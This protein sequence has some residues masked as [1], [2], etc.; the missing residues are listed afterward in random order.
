[1]LEKDDMTDAQRAYYKKWYAENREHKRVYDA[2][3]IE[4]RRKYR[5]VNREALRV[6]SQKR[7]NVDPEGHR[8]RFREYYRTHR[9]AMEARGRARTAARVTF[10]AEIKLKSG[11][12]DCG[13]NKHP[14]ALHF[15]HV[16][17]RKSFSFGGEGRYKPWKEL[18]A[19]MAKCEVRCANCHSIKTAERRGPL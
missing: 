1:M 16:R 13:F 3:R 19:E 6:D 14:D 8:A 15:D 10:L 12:V 9:G 17:G 11:C 5:D 2:A 7:R 18:Y 4:Y